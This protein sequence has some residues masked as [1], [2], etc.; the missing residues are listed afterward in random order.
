MSLSQSRCLSELP[1]RN[2]NNI[3]GSGRVG[4]EK[5]CPSFVNKKTERLS[6]T[7]LY[8]YRRAAISVV[9][10]ERTLQYPN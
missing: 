9:P 8:A 5:N 6:D 2:K 10:L 1:K 3:V 4:E 7:E